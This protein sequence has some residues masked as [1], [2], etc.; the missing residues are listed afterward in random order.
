MLDACSLGQF[1]ALIGM[2]TDAGLLIATSCDNFSRLN[3]GARLKLGV[4]AD[5]VEVSLEKVLLQDAFYS[6]LYNYV[7]EHDPRS[8]R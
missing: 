6:S 2:L 8:P 5:D 3:V 1:S 4:L 7:R